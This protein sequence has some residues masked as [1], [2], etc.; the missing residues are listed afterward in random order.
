MAVV[1]VLSYQIA[2]C[3]RKTFH[4]SATSG[5][6][7]TSHEKSDT[8]TIR[9]NDGLFAWLFF[10]LEISSLMAPVPDHQVCFGTSKDGGQSHAV[11]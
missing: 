7:W 6:I 3:C 8:A 1:T 2:T 9:D 11:G 4:E 10:G 5:G